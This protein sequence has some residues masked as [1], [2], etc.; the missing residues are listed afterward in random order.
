MSRVVSSGLLRTIGLTVASL[1]VVAAA[2]AADQKGIEYARPNGHPLLLD[3]HV[4]DGAGPF[5]AAILVHG[6]GFDGGSR[7]TNM[8]P[9]FQPLAD[10][11]FVWFS[12]DYRMA[13]EFRFPE[14]REDL[15]TAIRWVKANARAYKV[16]VSK[17]VLSGESA[18]G[19]LVNYAATHETPQTKVA[20][21]VDLYGP[22]DYEKVARQ[23]QAYPARFNMT[24]INGHQ[25]TGGGIWFFG[26]DDYDEPGFAKLRGISP[27][28]AVH[29]GMPPFLEIHG[30]RDDQVPY[31]QSTLM[32]D[33]MHKVG[34][35]CD[36]ITIEAGGHGMGSWKDADQQHYKA[37]M[38]AWLRKTLELPSMQQT[39]PPATPT[40]AAPQ[41]GRGG[42]FARPEP[43]DF[44][45]HDGWTSIF[46]GRT[47]TGWDGNPEVWS[48]ENGV[49]TA[50]STTERRIGSTHLIWRG[51][52]PDD[53]ELKLEMKLEG[54]IHSGIAYRSDVDPAR[55]AA[56]GGRGAPLGVP[57]NPKWTLYGPGLDYDYDRT[58]SG[59]VEERG[60]DRREIAWRGAIVQTAPGKRPRVVG[61]IGEG[62]A[63]KALLKADDW[64]QIHIIA[65]G[66]Q[67]THI[68]N[69]Q[70][71]VVLIDDDPA[72]FRAKGWIGLQIEQF[73]TGRVNFRNIW[74]KAVRS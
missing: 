60:T 41:P 24:S 70:T 14:A 12:I 68:I 20:A 17:I 63:L 25:K 45:D 46:D 40:P 38:I 32:C 67:L 5:P 53:F 37:G 35:V 2:P 52:Q 7:A 27:V 22:T 16:D 74:I 61:S 56:G 39:A 21:V 19:F 65:R 64:N 31:E 50:V 8:A 42:G 18:G 3:L 4:P 59:N 33:A 9:T 34:A 71:M 10:A 51:G 57:A 15:D 26:V 54:D 73:G 69:G 1:A 47:L 58:M 72:Y 48:V 30:T 28:H 49:I 11:G 66:H 36:I 62:E 23:R 43:L 6:G 55:A 44:N 29:A 13:P